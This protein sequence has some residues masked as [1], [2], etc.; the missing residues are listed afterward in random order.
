V[1]GWQQF[2][3]SPLDGA[4]LEAEAR[5]FAGNLLRLRRFDGTERVLDFGCGPGYVARQIAPHVGSV[6]LWDAS[7]TVRRQAASDLR[8][9]NVRVLDGLDPEDAIGDRYDLIIVNSVVQYMTEHELR[10]WLDAW[11]R[12]LRPLGE[13]VVAD[14]AF[15]PPHVA[16]E[17]AEWVWFC[18]RHGVLLSAVR[19]AWRSQARY[20]AALADEGLHVH[21]RAAWDELA[22][23]AG[24]R[25]ELAD[26]NLTLRKRRATLVLS[27]AR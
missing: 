7:P 16:R 27:Q 18:A 26:A 4:H 2:W 19:F 20:R 3:A 23:D 15:Q 17:L 21:D 9:R 22:V 11:S 10:R 1:S 12:Y 24:L 14:V 8:H 25:L 13:V 5:Y 6:D